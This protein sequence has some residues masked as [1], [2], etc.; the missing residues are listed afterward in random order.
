MVFAV[1]AVC[2]LADLVAQGADSVDVKEGLDILYCNGQTL[3]AHTGIDIFVL[4]LGV[5]AVPVIIELRKDDIP[6]FHE[7]VAFAA[8]DILGTVAPFFSAVIIDLGAGAAGT[9][10]VLPEVVLF[11]KLIDAV[12]RNVHVI[13]P[14]LESFV[15]VLIDRRIEA[16]G[17]QADPF[18]Q[19]LPCPRDGLFFEIITEGEVAQHLKE[20]AVAG[21]LADILQITRA[22]TFL[23]C[24]HTCAG[25]DLLSCEIRL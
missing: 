12:L 1:L 9:G 5:I 16:V 11:T 25:R 19:K 6:D 17:I 21:S 15:V 8:H 13:L 22:D 24:S 14:D 2:Q 7:A 23:A 10:A 3:Q 20:G 18:G 4:E